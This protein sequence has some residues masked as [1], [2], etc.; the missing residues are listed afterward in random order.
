M[1]RSAG[2]LVGRIRA[3]ACRPYRSF[4]II[5]PPAR[6]NS[7][8]FGWWHGTLRLPY[9]LF[10]GPTGLALLGQPETVVWDALEKLFPAVQSRV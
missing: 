5:D 8:W 3:K 9:C 6:R 2:A 7:S 1:C 4:V 10:E